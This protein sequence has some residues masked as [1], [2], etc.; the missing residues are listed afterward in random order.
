MLIVEWFCAFI[1]S[2]LPMD[3]RPCVPDAPPKIL[4]V[5]DM[6]KVPCQL[7]CLA[8]CPFSHLLAPFP[9]LLPLTPCHLPLFFCTTSPNQANYCRPCSSSRILC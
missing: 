5:L 6:Q 7:Q 9:S 4:C 8:P 1:I 3:I 2:L